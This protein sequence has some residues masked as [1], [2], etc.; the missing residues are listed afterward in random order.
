MNAL[1]ISAL[2]G[3]L[4]M[5]SGIL[6]KQKS[7]IRGLALTGLLVTIILNVMEIYGFHLFRINV[8]GMMSFDRFS[9]FFNKGR[10]FA[11]FIIKFVVSFVI[12]R[13]G[14]G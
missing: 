4:M 1:I 13:K 2:M 14:C 10:M 12:S 8:T 3:V 9:L 6:L 5:F 11:L 7:T